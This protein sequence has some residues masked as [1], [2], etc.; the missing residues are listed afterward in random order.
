MKV[1]F[2]IT[3]DWYFWSH[4]LVLAR[5]VRDAGHQVVLMTHVNDLRELIRSEGFA[6][7]DWDLHRGSINPLTE[8]RSLA[9]V[10]SV[11]GRWSPDLVHHVTLKSVIYGGLVARLRR[12]P[13]VNAIAGL[14]V[15]FT[16]RDFK[17]KVLRAVL[18]RLLKL[19]FARTSA[20]ALF[21]VPADRDILIN[22]GVVRP[23]QCAVIR[24]AGV[25]LAE[26]EARPE[27]DTQAPL[28]VLPARLLWDKGVG[29]FV[30]AARRL[31]SE[32]V[33][34]RFAIVGRFDEQNPGGVPGSIV[35]KW[36]EEG[37]VEFWGL[38]NDMPQVLAGTNIVCLPTFYGEGVPK[39]LLEACA[40]GRAIVATDIPGCREVVQDGVN[41]LLV[42][43]KNVD[44]LAI[45]LK[46]LIENE[47][48]R[49]EMGRAGRK[50][51]EIHFSDRAVVND[52]FSLYQ[53]VT[54]DRFVRQT[55][56]TARNTGL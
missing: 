2:L 4:R 48:L 21:Q 39:I 40:C 54:E 29:E 25:D 6:L 7:E 45:G 1:L 50:L 36:I 11:Y 30:E 26:F 46:L 35:S 32:G 9:G 51:A 13:S 31:R 49:N 42:T 3:E 22:S 5:A 41:G 44:A 53:R 43:P 55:H 38:R 47:E 52:T 18:K 17:S 14:G 28:V 23:E 33:K 37:V 12:I 16:R 34:A 8:L 20:V 24:G 56:A 15:I 10:Y 19:V 27:P